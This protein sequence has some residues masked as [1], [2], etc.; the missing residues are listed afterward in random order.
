MGDTVL[1]S[2][3]KLVM[4]KIRN[5]DLVARF[6]GEEFVIFMRGISTA[7]ATLVAD[8]L[9]ES[10]SENQ[11]TLGEK[12]IRVTVSI[13]LV[14]GPSQACFSP[15]DMIREADALLYQAKKNGRNQVC[16]GNS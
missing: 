8:R 1:Q 9:R 4:Q 6:G 10:I 3:C 2:T 13:G 5:E 11:V 14:S 15:D 16:S 7:D 12:T